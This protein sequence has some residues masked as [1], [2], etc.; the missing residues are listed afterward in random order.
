M[1]PMSYQNAMMS[2]QQNNFV[3]QFG[4]FMGLLQGMMQQQMPTAA[5]TTSGVTLTEL[6]EDKESKKIKST[7]KN[8]PPSP[9]S[10]EE[11]EQEVL[12]VADSDN[13]EELLK[14]FQGDNDVDEDELDAPKNTQESNAVSSDG[15]GDDD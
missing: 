9:E 2:Q 12:S 5:A 11:E 4:Q 1:G 8:P 15:D 13:T 14:R 10:K 3:G 7:K 6:S